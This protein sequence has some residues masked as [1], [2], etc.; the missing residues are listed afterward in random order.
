MAAADS[1]DGFMVA[2]DLDGGGGSSWCRERDACCVCF[3]LER[4]RDNVSTE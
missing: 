2:A 3:R 4:T 1:N